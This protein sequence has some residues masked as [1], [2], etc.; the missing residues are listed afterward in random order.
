L[1][2]CVHDAPPQ[3]V[4]PFA[5]DFLQQQASLRVAEFT[6]ESRLGERR[7]KHLNQ[8]EEEVRKETTFFEFVKSFQGQMFVAASFHLCATVTVFVPHI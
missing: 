8:L 5:T 7:N 4:L 1:L 3:V 2:R 6:S